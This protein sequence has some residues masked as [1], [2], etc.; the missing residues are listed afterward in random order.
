[1]CINDILENEELTKLLN[2]S[3]GKTYNKYKLYFIIEMEDFI[4]EVNMFLIQRLESF[5]NQK[6]T[7]KT[8][9][10]MLVMS[11]AKNCIQSAN[12]QSKKHNKLEF[13]NNTLSLDYEFENADNNKLKAMDMIGCNIDNA[14]INLLIDEILNMKTLSKHQKE[15]LKLMAQGYTTTDISKMLD[16][17]TSCINI[18]F[19][20][21]KEKIV[22]KYAY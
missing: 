8:Y 21:A 3:I 11:C 13:R 7:L 5:D 10:P 15:I 19:Q 14:D 16:K 4:Q 20:R 22:K 9:L 6:S 12:G 17:S 2:G 18:T 1:M